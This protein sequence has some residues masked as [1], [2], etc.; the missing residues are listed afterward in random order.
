MVIMSLMP[1][2]ISSHQGRG[3]EAMDKK[4]AVQMIKERII[5]HPRTTL[6]KELQDQ[7]RTRTN[8]Y[9]RALKLKD[10]H[11][12]QLMKCAKCYFD[13]GNLGRVPEDDQKFVY[14]RFKV[15]RPLRLAWNEL[16]KE[17]IDMREKYNTPA[18][19]IVRLKIGNTNF[20]IKP[21]YRA[22]TVIENIGKLDQ[23]HFSRGIEIEGVFYP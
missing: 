23:H 14:S 2:N 5:N 18:S 7:L 8:Y 13:H 20:V 16:L 15:T 22:L 1:A 11:Q 17:I 9:I 12:K 4:I 19:G 3:W 21:C 10:L 6:Q